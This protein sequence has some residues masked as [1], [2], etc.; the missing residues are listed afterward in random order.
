MKYGLVLPL[1]FLRRMR[2][3]FLSV[4]NN[5]GEGSI[6]YYVGNDINHV[7]HLRDC[8][9]ICRDDFNPDLNGVELINCENP[10]LYF[11]K[12]SSKFKR[13]FLP[14][15]DLVFNE[16]Y[17]SYIHKNTEIGKR[18]K[19]GPNCVIG[20]CKISEEVEIHSNVTIYSNTFIGRNTIIESGTVIGST[21]VMWVWDGDERVYLEQLGGVF[22]EEDIRIGSLVEIVRGSC[23]EMTRIGKGTCIA[24]GTLIGHGCQIGKY[25]HFANGVKLGGSAFISDYCFLGSGSIV[26]AGIK[27]LEKDVII[28]AGSVVV[29][30][31]LDM[32][33]YVGA[34]AIK[35][36]NSTGKM[37]G[38]PTWRK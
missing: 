1:N 16:E 5:A 36:K 3:N 18:V 31:I 15:E 17:K 28:G 35:I 37:S 7:S 23:N 13:N 21:G 6:T 32:G 20:E 27:I 19:I 10:Q 8:T 30:N 2:G 34:P 14:S 11:Y 9:L 12:L 22:L 4:L 26:S 25:T 24:H 38:I 33:V 29:K